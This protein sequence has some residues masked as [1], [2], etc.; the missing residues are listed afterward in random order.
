M[1]IVKGAK[2]VI[3]ARVPITPDKEPDGEESMMGFSLSFFLCF[4]SNFKLKAENPNLHSLISS[5]LSPLLLLLLLLSS[6]SLLISSPPLSSFL[7]L[8][9]CR[10]RFDGRILLPTLPSCFP[11]PSSSLP[12]S[13]FFSFFASLLR[14]SCHFAHLEN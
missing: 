2:N 6:S 12:L 7:S 8:F 4:V 1:A 9:V 10:I 5:S 3:A 13:F 14:E 11:L